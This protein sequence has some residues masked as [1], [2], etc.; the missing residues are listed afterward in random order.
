MS[1]H[2]SANREGGGS[3]GSQT[4]SVHVDRFGSRRVVALEGELDLSTSSILEEALSQIFSKAGAE[5]IEFDLSRLDFLD[6]TGLS[7]LVRFKKRAEN[8]GA[9]VILSD[10]QPHARRVLEITSLD[11]F[12]G[13]EDTPGTSAAPD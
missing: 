13:L 7:L 9:R 12:F 2:E 11:L 5:A 8:L 4:F 10:P 6:A 1:G 3:G